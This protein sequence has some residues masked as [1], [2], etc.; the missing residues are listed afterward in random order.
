MRK[1][2]FNDGQ[3][4]RCLPDPPCRD[5]MH[6]DSRGSEAKIKEGLLKSTGG[7]S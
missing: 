6:K 4:E 7:L 3:L 2:F 5:R 1:D